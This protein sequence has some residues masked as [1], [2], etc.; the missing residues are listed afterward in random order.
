MRLITSCHG[1][2]VQE[3]CCF[4]TLGAEIITDSRQLESSLTQLQPEVEHAAGQP[5]LFAFDH[6]FQPSGLHPR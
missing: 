2:C 5:E 4:V 6:L 1:V 3:S